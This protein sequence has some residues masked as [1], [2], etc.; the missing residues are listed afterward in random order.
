M[1]SMAPFRS[2][3]MRVSSMSADFEHSVLASRLNSWQRKSNLRPTGLSG[4][5]SASRRA[6][7][8]D[9]GSQ[10]VELLAHVG[11]A[12]QQRHF[13]GEA[14]LGQRRRA[15]QQLGELALEAGAHRA[16]L[17]RGAVGGPLAQAPR[18]RRHG[19]SITTA[20]A[21]PSAARAAAN[22]FRTS[23]R[24]PDSAR[25]RAAS[26]SSLSSAPVLLL[27]DAAH[28]QQ[29]VGRRRGRAGALAD[30]LD[31]A[32]QLGQQGAIDAQRL[33]LL[34]AGD[35]EGE[36]DVAALHAAADG[37]A[38]GV[39][40]PVEALRHA[41]ADLQVAAVDAARLPDP[42]PPLIRSLRPGVSR[43]ACNQ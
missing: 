12:D 26:A 7:L 4:R 36:R 42:A 34:L 15:F 18:S 14:L 24:V 35:G 30:L 41:A 33:A 11:L 22:A 17:R 37:G 8:G 25:S 27:D 16:D 31:Q 20:S 21:R 9:V 23:S 13:L 19:R 39:F 6:R 1:R 32:R 38:G 3:P 2:M 10:P 28:A 43:H 40:Q 5:A 29:A